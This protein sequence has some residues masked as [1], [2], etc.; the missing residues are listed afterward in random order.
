MSDPPKENAN[1]TAA[2]GRFSRRSFVAG[3]AG[4][5]CAAGLGRIAGGRESTPQSTAPYGVP[6][7]SLSGM[8]GFD[9][10][11]DPA[12]E[13]AWLGTLTHEAALRLDASGS[14]RSGVVIDWNVSADGLRV[15]LRVRPDALFSDG[16][17][18]TAGDVA[19]SLE[20][21][22]SMASNAGSGPWDRI[23]GIEAIDGGTVRLSLVG[24]DVTLMASLTSARALIVPSRW[25]ERPWG[26]TPDRLPPGSGPF[27][28]TS[29]EDRRVTLSRHPAY[30]QV[31]RPYL[32]G[33]VV[34]ASS[35]TL[36]RTTELVTGAVDV[37]IDVPLLDIPT[38]RDDPN[39]TLA[40]GPANRLCLLSVNL[41]AGPLRDRRPRALISSAIDRAAVLDAAVASEGEPATGL[42]PA[43]SWV[44]GGIELEA[45]RRSPDDV[46]AEL[47]ADGHVAGLGLRLI[48][49]ERDS[50]IA[51]ACVLLQ[52][53]L[54]RAGIAVTLDLLDTERLARV[55][56]EEP[57][58]L[59]AMYSDFWRD[60][61]EL[62]RPLLHA[63]GQLNLGQYT[64]DRVSS[65]I[66]LA[67]TTRNPRQRAQLYR[68]IQ[69]IARTEVPLIPL[70]F[71]A[72]YD[73]MTT[74]I[75]PYDAYPPVSG[76]AMRQVRM[77]PPDRSPPG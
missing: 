59:L 33:L 60:P 34:A 66:D 40:G 26:D 35:E 1:L 65:L 52:E 49:D 21:C 48:A 11:R 22:R 28:V 46:R 56:R 24:P 43:V 15:D 23:T 71:P 69:Q 14:I 27:M 18:V 51:N 77:E 20:R 68:V 13:T 42:F 57:W 67:I 61:D 72:Y 54:A 73:A 19:A 74:R 7:V 63:R 2:G 64:S 36:P 30:R 32:A 29:I 58:D 50:S 12:M 55:S 47:A 53:Q 8:P 16:M 39:L 17:L 6:I 9:P 31:G 75:G 62:V 76:L 5:A 25:A 4:V 70:F 38:L 44:Q 41:R 37:V 10:M 3:V 45:A